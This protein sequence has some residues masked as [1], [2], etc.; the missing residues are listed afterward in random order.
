MLTREKKQVIYI[1]F[2]LI[3][4]LGFL[5]GSVR[6]FSPD[7]T[8]ND[9][10]RNQ[11]EEAIDCGGSCLPCSEIIEAEDIKVI[12]TALLSI[13]PDTYD[14]VAFIQNPNNLFGSGNFSYTFNFI[15]KSGS[16][17]KTFQDTAYI[18]PAQGRYLM[19][20][21]EKIEGTPVR[22]EAHID[23]VTWEKFNEYEAPS[24]TITN[25]AF[26][27]VSSGTDYAVAKGL[28]RN[29][30]PYDFETVE[31]YVVLRDVLGEIIAMNRTDMQTVRSGEKRDFPV[32]WKYAFDGEVVSI[33]A[34]ALTNMF[35]NQN[36]IKLFFPGGRFQQYK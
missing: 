7:P 10:I 25:K 18:L 8:C 24:L 36:F 35:G 22:V 32:V 14:A 33:D 11:G 15:D 6:L 19:L 34:Q 9:G 1:L 12:E 17:V 28:V 4:F 27:K 29:Q 3:L 20:L 13:S 2:F 5:G 26:E 21:E 31:I 30:S 23:A 16:I